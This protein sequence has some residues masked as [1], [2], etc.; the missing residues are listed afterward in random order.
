M[1]LK[2]LKSLSIREKIKK[3]GK[4]PVPYQ[5]SF[6]LRKV[7]LI[8]DVANISALKELRLL[9]E[10]LQIKSGDFKIV[11]S[12]EK[13]RKE[14]ERSEEIVTWKEVSISGEVK[15]AHFLQISSEG[16]DL[17]ITFAQENN[18]LVQLLTASV[19]AGIKAGNRENKLLDVV[20]KSDDAPIFRNELINY[21][22]Q[23]KI[24]D[25]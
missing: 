12:S 11:I 14:I 16:A 24:N 5:Y 18:S 2:G 8:V 3:A 4:N 22:K 19:H 1:I 21:L 25:E 20:I 13:H 17:L 15:N 23:L 7:S 10:D 6:P 9:K